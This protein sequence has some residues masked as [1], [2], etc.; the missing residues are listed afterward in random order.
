MYLSRA[1]LNTRISAAAIALLIAT[2]SR[3]SASS[4]NLTA[5][6]LSQS[7]TVTA[8]STGLSD[9]QI[10]SDFADKV[11]IPSFQM[12]ANKAAGL[13]AAINGFAQNP[14]DQT[15]K[16][17]RNAWVAARFPWEQT[18]CFGFGPIKSE[19]YDGHFDTW[20]IDENDVK[21]ILASGDQLTPGYI[22][23]LRD[24]D[25]GFHVIEYLLFGPASHKQPSEFTERELAFLKVLGGDFAKVANDM[26]NSWSKGDEDNPAYR[27][28]IATAGAKENTTYPTLQAAT[29][30]MIGGML[31]SLDEVANSKIGKPLTK[32]DAKLAESRFS[33][34]TLA[35]LKSNV[36]GSQNVYLGR[37]Q[38]AHTSGKGLS[39]YV[40]GVNPALDTKV[41]QQFQV[42][43]D[44]LAK[45]PGPFEKSVLDPQAADAVKAAQNAVN[46]LHDTL[47]KE[48]KPLLGSS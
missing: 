47:D 37:F 27:Q 5:A 18:E 7:A 8:A 38:P 2:S 22:E 36:L 9:R 33:L 28:V 19:G 15:L 32:K 23:R 31:D 43:L 34:N 6:S 17:A 26:A 12:V 13:S 42:A 3:S 25:K 11:V 1:R 16:A 40:A 45:I 4:V 24:S 39:A 41:K 48:V 20:P 46:T 30:E 44:A 14:N 21:T 10:L 29:Q 35:D